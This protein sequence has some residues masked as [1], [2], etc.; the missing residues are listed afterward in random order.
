VP[1]KTR[2]AVMKNAKGR[3]VKSYFD[4]TKPDGGI[5]ARCRCV[6]HIAEFYFA[7]RKSLK[8]ATNGKSPRSCRTLAQGD[9]HDYGATRPFLVPSRRYMDRCHGERRR[10]YVF[11]RID[12]ADD[13][14]LERCGGSRSQKAEGR[15]QN[16][17][18]INKSLSIGSQMTGCGVRRA[19]I[20]I[21]AFIC[22]YLR[23]NEGSAGCVNSLPDRVNCPPS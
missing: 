13:R 8:Q 5:R 12:L 17:L 9:M 7:P 3:I 14:L 18:S 10:A 21:S 16:G 23:L 19:C 2:A 15:R 11:A 1:T 20:C 6:S 4:Q 22:V